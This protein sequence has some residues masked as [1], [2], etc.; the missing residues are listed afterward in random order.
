MCVRVV[1]CLLQLWLGSPTHFDMHYTSTLCRAIRPC[2]G[3]AHPEIWRVGPQRL[4]RLGTPILGSVSDP[5]P[6]SWSS[7]RPDAAVG[8]AGR[9]GA[10]LSPC[11]RRV[12]REVP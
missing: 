11:I 5:C 3:P 6:P 7:A 8:S 10:G 1:R 2:A 12:A 4:V 9:Q